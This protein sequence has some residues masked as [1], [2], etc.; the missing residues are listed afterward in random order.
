[1]RTDV[2]ENASHRV[3]MR[4]LKLSIELACTALRAY[5]RSQW[6]TVSWTAKASPTDM[7]DVHSSLIRCAEGSTY[8]LRTRP[9]SSSDR[10]L[11][12]RPFAAPA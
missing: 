6:R 12:T 1:M 5:S 11:T 2:V 8:S 7:N 4:S 3:R 9:A 10:S